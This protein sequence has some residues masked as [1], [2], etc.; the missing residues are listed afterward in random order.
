MARALTA[1]AI[2]AALLGLFATARPAAAGP[3]PL[4]DDGGTLEWYRTFDEAACAA[5]AQGKLVF[6]DSGRLQC[7][8]CRTLISR[9]LPSDVVRGRIRALAVGYADECDSP[10]PRTWSLFGRYLQGAVMLPLVGLVTPDL[11]WVTGW[12]GSTDPQTVAAHLE[13]AESFLATWRA[14]DRRTEEASR[15]AEEE[16]RRRAEEQAARDSMAARAKVTAAPPALPPAPPPRTPPQAIARAVE[17]APVPPK[18]AVVEPPVASAPPPPASAIGSPDGDEEDPCADGSCRLPCA[19]APAPNPP[20]PSRVEG[21]APR[22]AAPPALPPAAVLSTLPPPVHRGPSV[23]DRARAA[24]AAERWGDLA[25]LAD[26]ARAMP[27]GAERDEVDLLARR[28]HAWALDAMASAVA[29][30]EER[31]YADSLALLARVRREMGDRPVAIDAER[32]AEAISRSKEIDVALTS[33]TGDA[34]S[35]RRRAYAD[36]RGSRWVAL[37]RSRPA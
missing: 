1:P 20:A 5:R 32:G 14:N 21:P 16:R 6:V 25:R 2:A 37:F 15:R 3:H 23:L 30:A 27:P 12:S 11:Q 28:A 19:P 8:N 22:V 33:R 10:D 17:A 34:E 18:P 4:F 36:F 26:E 31:R 35:L 29:A 7:G 13:R 24:A 9:I